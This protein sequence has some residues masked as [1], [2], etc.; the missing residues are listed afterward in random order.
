MDTERALAGAILVFAMGCKPDLGRQAGRLEIDV[1]GILP[2]TTAVRAVLHG[3][4]DYVAESAPAGRTATIAVDSVPAG[5]LAFDVALSAGTSV[6]ASRSASAVIVDAETTRVGVDFGAGAADAGA[7]D[8]G[9]PFSSA[10]I[11]FVLPVDNLSFGDD[12][13]NTL[14]VARPLTG[15]AWSS[16]LSDASAHFNG[17]VQEVALRS[18]TLRLADAQGVAGIE[19]L[20]NA[21]IIIG[22]ADRGPRGDQLMA[23]PIAYLN[24]ATGTG[25]VA[26]EGVA[27]QLQALEPLEMALVG[28]SPSLAVVIEGTTPRSRTDSFSGQLMLSAVFDAYAR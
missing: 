17:P 13:S 4:Q 16:F 8:P 3:G 1:A 20:F 25:T 27:M 24:R 5:N 9:P 23:T 18:G 21:Q 2:G 11:P 14:V 19:G 26:F 22:L 7:A 6:L 15:S 10:P 28:A 12:A